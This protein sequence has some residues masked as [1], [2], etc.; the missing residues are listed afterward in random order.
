MNKQAYQLTLIAPAFLGDA[1]QSG[2]WRTPPIEALL[3]EWWRVAA[4][5]GHGFE[6][7]SLREEEDRPF[8]NAWLDGQAARC[9][10]SSPSRKAR[11]PPLGWGP[12]T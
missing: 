12:T 6:H 1:N 5:L 10:T 9:R 4:A 3:R 8:G 7:R 2:T 11:K